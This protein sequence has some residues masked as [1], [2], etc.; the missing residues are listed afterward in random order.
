MYGADAG[1]TLRIVPILGLLRQDGGSAWSDRGHQCTCQACWFAAPFGSS[2][3]RAVAN[4]NQHGENWLFVPVALE[5]GPLAFVTTVY[6]TTCAHWQV[7]KG[8]QRRGMDFQGTWGASYSGTTT[9]TVA[10]TYRR[11]VCH[12]PW[13]GTLR[14]D[15]EKRIR[16]GDHNAAAGR[17]RKVAANR[18]DHCTIDWTVEMTMY[19]QR[20]LL[21]LLRHAGTCLIF[22]LWSLII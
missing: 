3:D 4:V 7:D 20:S 17:T 9:T 1:S 12:W 5:W 18:Q 6:Q 21:T 10:A 2:S 14:S 13:C 15:V 19:T 8:S 22:R 11:G 16:W